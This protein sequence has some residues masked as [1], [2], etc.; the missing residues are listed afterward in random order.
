MSFLD[1]LSFGFGRKLPLILQTEAAECGLASLAMVAGYH[2]FRTDLASMRRLFLV[3][4]KG[5]TLG[6]LIGMANAMQMATRPVKLEL[7]DMAQLR[8]PCIL[9]WN[10]NHFVVLKE[11]NTK[12]IVIHDPA[13][14]IRKLNW[15][16]VSDSFTG[17]ALELWPNTGFKAATFKQHIKL[18][19]LMGNVTGLYKSF[20]QVLLLALSLEVFALVSPFFLQWVIDNVIVTADR[21]LLTTLALGFGLLMLMQQ[22]VSTLRSWVIMYMATTLNIQWRANVFTHLVSLP[23]QYFEKR[24]I[25]DVVSRFSSVDIIQRTLTTSFVEA[26]LDGVMTVL[27]L[28]MMFIYSPTLAWIAVAAM[29]LYGVGRWGWYRPLRNA[30]EEQIIHAAKQQSHFLETIRGVK[31]IKLFQRQDERRS[32]WLT[33]LVDQINADLRTQKL[34]VLYRL[35]NGV[36]F[37]LERVIII[38]FGASL[39]LDGEFTVGVLMA[40]LA[41]K[42]QFD[43]RVSG[44]I[45]KVVEVKMLRLQGER[46]ADIVLAEPEDTHRPLPAIGEADLQPSIDI[47]ELRYRYADQEPW[48]LDGVNFHIDAGESVAI[49]GPSG[50]GKSTLIN[51]MLGIRPPNSG[52]VMIG[53]TSV[54][55]IG[56]DTLRQMVGTVMQDDNLF[57]GSIADNISFFDHKA[58][59]AWVEECAKMAAI[60]E[61]IMAMPMAYSTLIG[62]MGTAL[63]G[64]QKQRILLARAL[65]KRPSIL[66]LDEATSHLDLARETMVNTAIKALKVTRV[67]VAHRPETIASADRVI[68]MSGGK[69]VVDKKV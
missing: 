20:G 62:D 49:V 30:T 17:V 45:D 42:D 5:T 10:F 66:F 8:M 13:F 50:C 51:A 3:S 15:E 18:R 2:G 27:T 37:G 33:L 64:G 39:I 16:E 28:V 32:T 21:D 1:N 14:G 57:A 46:L 25:G 53:G 36:L 61:E 48:V 41:Y 55:Q 22:G 54:S 44:L 11:V 52:D 67:I 40:F 34:H 68:E 59:Q 29:A 19:E 43:M 12:G 58:D 24:H 6:H 26:I 63:S 23:V 56:L 4:I 35:M 38:W 47:V 31:T 60:H 65:Y 7:E 69:V 9:H